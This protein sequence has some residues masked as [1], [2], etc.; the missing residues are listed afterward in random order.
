MR[1]ILSLFFALMMAFSVSAKVAFLVPADNTSRDALRFE[2]VDGLEQSPERRAYDW[3]NTNFVS[4]GNG[5]FICLSD[6]SNLSADINAIWI[7][8]DR[9]GFNAGDFDN[10]FNASVKAN[11]QAFLNAGGNL[12]LCKQATRLEKD[13][14]GATDGQSSTPGE[15]YVI[16]PAYND[17]GYRDPATWGVSTKFYD[18]DGWGSYKG[19]RMYKDAPHN[20]DNDGY[21]ELIW[22]DNRKLTDNNCGMEIGWMGLNNV[23][24]R[25][26]LAAFQTRNNCKVLGGWANG[27]GCHYG[28]IIE[29]YPTGT[30]RGTV[31]MIGLAAYSWITN[32]DHGWGY[33]NTDAIT[34]GALEYLNARPCALDNTTPMEEKLADDYFYPSN[35]TTFRTLH[36][37]CEDMAA[38]YS[39]AS[40]P[41]GIARIYDGK[42]QFKAAGTVTLRI[43][44]TENREFKA[45]PKGTYEYD[46]AITFAYADADAAQKVINEDFPGNGVTSEGEPA[47]QMAMRLHP[48]VRGMDSVSYTITNHYDATEGEAYKKTEDGVTRL[49]F[50][51]SGKVLLTINLNET[52]WVEAW[53]MGAKQF[54][55]VIEFNYTQEAGPVFPWPAI[56]S[57]ET[58][59][60]KSVIDLPETVEGLTVTYSIGEGDDATL[61]GHTLTLDDK[62]SG[63]V[64]V[65]ASVT[66]DKILVT[67][68]VGT[69]NYENSLSFQKFRPR[70]LDNTTPMEEK[71]ADDYFYPSNTT[72][73]RTLH[74]VCEDMPAAYSIASDPNGIARIHE[75]KLQFK[76]AGT[77]TLHITLTENREFKNWPK[78]TYEYDRE[79]TFAYADAQAAQDGPNFTWP[80]QFETGAVGP[81]SVITLPATVAELPVSYEVNG[82]ASLED[83]EMTLANVESGSVTVNASVTETGYHEAW[84][85]G[86]YNYQN[87]LT[88]HAAEVGYLLPAA[89][90]I[91]HLKFSDD[92]DYQDQQPEYNAAKWFQDNYIAT[93]QGRF[94]TV[95]ELPTLKAKGIKALWVNI[96][97]VNIDNVNGL[98]TACLTGDGLK[99]YIRA[100]GNVLLTKQATRLAYTMGRIGY[101]PAFNAGEYFEPTNPGESRS[102]STRMGTDNEVDEVL[103]MSGHRLFADML[104]WDDAKHVF[105]VGENCWQTNNYCSWQ[106]FMRKEGEETHYDNKKIQRVHDF[107]QD[108]HAT[109]FG[110]QGDVTDYCYSNVVEFN[111][112]ENEWAGRILAIGATGYQW[113]SANPT[114]ELD[115]VKKLT[116]N[117]LSYLLDEP[118]AD[119]VY[120]RNGLTPGIYGTICFDYAVEAGHIE[121]AEIYE[122]TSFN[123]TNDGV[124]LTQ[125]DAMVAGRPYFF[126]ATANELRLTYHGQ[127]VAAGSYH[128]LVGH[129]GETTLHITPKDNNYI[130]YNNELLLVNTDDIELPSYRAYINKYD[131]IP[132]YSEPTSNAPR[133][134]MAI[135]PPLNAPTAV[136]AV[137]MQAAQGVYDI[138]GRKLSA[139]QGNGFY[140]INGQKVIITQ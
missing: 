118:L 12:F 124:I 136:E 120:T 48:S 81:N 35:T 5:Q 134:I 116:A 52:D 51:K 70:A 21:L 31:I 38:A 36:S 16:T 112:I 90:S 108:W 67:W 10:L 23:D 58:V 49:Y 111:A 114:T 65:H 109:V 30:R 75:G 13:L 93:G 82:D 84:P 119:E 71:L 50:S 140:I 130:L 74:P 115:N 99:T 66:E 46:R 9:V 138:M 77:V 86:V 126:L 79:I 47:V 117:S 29:F 73:F 121:G 102:I 44:L 131:E 101:E 1:K 104:S 22:T 32:N 85:A 61:E 59:P 133:R 24:D 20:Q 98:L 87:S 64:T 37:L 132:A 39:I 91:D 27:N 103:D 25:D 55:R 127:R 83:N 54:E 123:A 69:Y 72:T 41:N 53:P 78:G 62:A 18:G 95:D 135:E 113:G 63:H 34:K 88:F 7:Y 107:E 8:V 125:V 80:S 122:L 92:P 56:F 110:I 2:E 14:V 60:A 4:P 94:V 17:G 15:G 139:P 76:A 68:P 137:D 43:A 45:W 129:I 6:L 19:H 11:L 40:D 105:L 57:A 96:E 26:H 33:E 89:E 42:L 100:G 28:G 128:G 97:R 106:D 3:F